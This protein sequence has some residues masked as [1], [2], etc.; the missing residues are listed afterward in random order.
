MPRIRLIGIDT[1]LRRR[2][3]ASR[4]EFESAYGASVG[5]ERETIRDVVT[6]TLEMLAKVPRDPVFGGYL[7][8]DLDSGRVIGTCGFKHG[9]EKDGRV[10]IAYYTFAPFEGKGYATAMATELVA[11]ARRSDRVREIFAHTLPER[12][13]S[14]R[15]LEKAGLRW[16]DEIVDPEDGRVWLWRRMNC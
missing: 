5:A 4:D 12:N 2:L 1:E 8:V 14:T 10:E 16:D 15:I 11:L 9:P 13:A 3:D 7:S 6:Q